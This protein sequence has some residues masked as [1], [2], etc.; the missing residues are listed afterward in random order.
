MLPS[1]ANF[2]FARHERADGKALY[3]KLK[4]LGILVR[5]F[6]KERLRDYNRITIGSREQMQ[7]L[8]QAL[9]QIL[10]EKT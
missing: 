3:L 6:D 2:L 5:H 4:E 1:Q 9:Q 10:E 8:I 7:A